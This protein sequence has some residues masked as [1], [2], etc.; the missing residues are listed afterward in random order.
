MAKKST[1]LPRA[2]IFDLDGTLIEDRGVFRW[3]GNAAKQTNYET[4]HL[5]N[6]RSRRKPFLGVRN[7]A[8]RVLR[9]ATDQ[10]IKDG[11]VELLTFL[12]EQDV[13]I[14][15]VSSG[16]QD[17]VKEAVQNAF[18]DLIDQ[19]HVYGTGTGKAV[20][21]ETDAYLIPLREHKIDTSHPT[22][23]MVIG[24]TVSNDLEPAVTSGMQA[25]YINDHGYTN[26]QIES[27]ITDGKIQEVTSLREVHAQLKALNEPKPTLASGGS[28]AAPKSHASTLILAREQPS[29]PF[30]KAL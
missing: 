14:F 8:E 25:I 3:A 11:A 16:T 5:N 23:I 19:E 4:L 28:T 22:D 17:N 1:A 15:V 30:T 10:P 26:K 12:K 2:V 21:P 27:L 7:G 13:A 29:V 6:H 9:R 24:D 20:K 18:G